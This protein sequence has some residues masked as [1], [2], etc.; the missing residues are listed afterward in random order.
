MT[1]GQF[2]LKFYHRPIGRIRQS[3]RNGGPIAERATEHHRREMVEAAADLGP[4]PSP[5]PDTPTVHLM[6]GRQ[7]WYQTVFCLHSLANAAQQPIRA[8]IYDD[9]TIDEQAA[10]LLSQL[11]PA[12]H[13]R[14]QE[15]LRAQLDRLL[16]RE[17]FPVLRERWDNYPNIRKLIDVHL[18]GHG[19]KLVLDSDLL[20][21]Q[22]PTA[23]LE[24]LAA[25]RALLHA[26]DHEESYG[27][28]RPLME[29]LAG[30]PL[31]VSLNVGVCGLRSES[32][33][34]SRLE[35]WTDELQRRERTHY[36]LEQA[37]VAM[38]AAREPA[39]ALSAADY[40][41]LPMRHEVMQPRAVMHHYVANS[42]RWYFRYGW[43]HVTK[44]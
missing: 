17:N 27:Y 21:F 3:L 25:P 28:S 16:P 33:D 35:H 42:K 39:L 10:A 6:T 14:F 22:R 34:W 29:S 9:G 38:L 12:V 31:P 18:G 44:R 37:L 1:P 8:E 43:R 19:W 23:L 7:F 40:I 20:F 15:E 24:W 4:L 30:A 2:L 13:I 32:L 11:G 5:A 26:I 41:T 36:F